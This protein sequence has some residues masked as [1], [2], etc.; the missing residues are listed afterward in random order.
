MKRLLYTLLNLI[1]TGTALLGQEPLEG[2]V[3]YL[4]TQHIYVRFSS[5]AGLADGDTLLIGGK[6]ALVIMN[7]SSTS[8]VC[9]PLGGMNV[10]VGTT[11]TG[12]PSAAG[13]ETTAVASVTATEAAVPGE[14]VTGTGEGEG[15]RIPAEEE[16]IRPENRQEIHGRLAVASYTNFANPY[17][18]GRQRLR[19][20]LSLDAGHVGNSK[21]SLETYVTFAHSSTNWEE[22][23]NNIFNGLKIYNLSA[24]YDFSD[25]TTL[26]AGRA[27]NPKLS[28]VGAIDGLQFEQKLGHFTAGA[29]AG[30]R[31]DYTDYS[32]DPSLLQF[33]AYA[34]HEVIGANGRMQNT[35]A[36][37]EQRNAGQTDR[38]FMYFQ[39]TNNLIKN[40]YFFGSVEADLYQ[41]TDNQKVTVFRLYNTF[42]SA[43]YRIIRP[44]S[45]SVSYSARNNLIYYESYKNFIERLLEDKTLQG[46]RARINYHP[47]GRLYL[48][49]NG[50]YRYRQDDPDPTKNLHGYA[51]YTL[52]PGIGGSVTGTVTWMQSSYINGMIYGGGYDHELLSGKL[53]VGVNYHYVDQTYGTSEQNV[54]QHVAEAS[55]YWAIWRK[56]SLS[57]N[58]EGTFEKDVNYHRVYLNLSQRF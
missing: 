24:R 52:L 10:A 44:L 19:Y 33:G 11:V 48:G 4:T 51:T 9:E 27:I 18:D 15:T 5:T 38:R 46:W 6:P 35:L 21:L 57:V 39:H 16:S 47:F 20:T 8:C 58:Y 12:I 13:G 55:L 3:T 31:P 53:N 29:F 23:K 54:N 32:I 22:I 1:L 37:I 40:L 36:I 28:S 30:S 25:K 42:L 2:K 56:L 26:L 7:H 41:V 17:S 43:R 34:G 14:A 49:V 45:V 50:G